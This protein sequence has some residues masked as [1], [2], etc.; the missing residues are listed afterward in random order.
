V[1]VERPWK[2][3]SDGILLAV[4]A[5]PKGGRDRIDGVT[6]FPDGTAALKARITAAPEDG[7]AN[8]ALVRL[9]A[10]AAG[11]APS[12]VQLVRG[13]SGRRKIFRLAGEPRR[14]AASL[15]AALDATAHGAP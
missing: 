2:I 13:T 10:R 12:A 6:Q 1:F 4:R 7:A 3:M 8:A 5:T 14:L 9:I 15:E 11:I